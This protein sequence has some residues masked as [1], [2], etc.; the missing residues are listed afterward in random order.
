[1]SMDTI[2][3]CRKDIIR[4]KIN[5]YTPTILLLNCVTEAIKTKH[6]S[7]FD[8][9]SKLNSIIVFLDAVKKLLV[10]FLLHD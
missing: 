10:I 1:M 8:F 5:A 6:S 9:H 7:F 4:K 3:I 2:R